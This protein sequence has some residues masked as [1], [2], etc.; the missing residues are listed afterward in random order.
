MTTNAVLFNEENIDFILENID[1]I[2]VSI[3][4][5]KE[6]MIMTG[7]IAMGRDI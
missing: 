3:D 4:G 5:T 1:E 6:I 7:Y 2:S